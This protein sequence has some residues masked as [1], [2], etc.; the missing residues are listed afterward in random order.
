MYK[1]INIY[2]YYEKFPFLNM[3][4]FGKFRETFEDPWPG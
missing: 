1:G 2:F 4:F 3:S